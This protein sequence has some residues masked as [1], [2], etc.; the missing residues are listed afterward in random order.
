MAVTAAGASSPRLAVGLPQT[1]EGDDPR[2]VAAYAIRAEALGF[3]GLWTLD[4][5]PGNRTAHW[6]LLDALHTLSHVAAVTEAARLGV[7]VIV[8]PRRNPAILARE[9]ATIDRLSAGRLTVGVGLGRVEDAD[10]LAGLGLAADRPVRRLVEGLEVMRALWAQGAAHH[11][12]DLYHFTGVPLE[13][14]PIQRPGP[15]VWFGGGA[16]AALSRAARLGDGWI[17]SG[18]SSIDDFV[19]Q[20][21]VVAREL[22][23]AGRQ[24]ARFTI[25][26]RVYIAVEDDAE[27][28]RRRLAGILD[29]MYAA[30]GLGERVAVAGTTEDCAAQLR[31]LAGAGAEELVLAPL[32][33]HLAQLDGLAEVARVLRTG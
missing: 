27:V 7:A 32:Y 18:S 16:P 13:P 28:A 5:P 33:A 23:A 2:A 4:S 14:K 3:S 1:L 19:E 30:P 31:R 29:A 9:L 25:A 15:P 17:G 24:R 8:L 20:A 11:D 12:G 26:K 6:P 22:E 10:T 21:A